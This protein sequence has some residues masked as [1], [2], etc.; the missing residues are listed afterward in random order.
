MIG[1]IWWLIGYD[2]FALG[3]VLSPI[4]LLPCRNHHLPQA[5]NP[6]KAIYPNSH[7][8]RLKSVT[9]PLH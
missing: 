3:G 6:I 2:S 4:R 9:D 8:I 1:V 5:T 7:K